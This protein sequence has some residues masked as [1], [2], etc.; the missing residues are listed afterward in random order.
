[1]FD[2]KKESQPSATG[3]AAASF[4]VPNMFSAAASGDKKGDLGGGF[5]QSKPP[6]DEKAPEKVDFSAAASSFTVGATAKDVKDAPKETAPD[7]KSTATK[8]SEYR[9][10][11]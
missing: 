11:L 9:W 7:K 6:G 4:A 3:D 2:T 10:A 1:M 5:F 8:S